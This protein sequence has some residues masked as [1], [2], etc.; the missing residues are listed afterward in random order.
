MYVYI[1]IH[2]VEM[3]EMVFDRF[4]SWSETFLTTLRPSFL[5]VLV[6]VTAVEETGQTLSNI[7]N[8]SISA[9]L[10][11]RLREPWQP[12]L[13]LIS[14]LSWPQKCVKSGTFHGWQ[15][16]CRAK[17]CETLEGGSEG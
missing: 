7:Q 14:V 11:V 3:L 2:I 5:P 1:Y 8:L 13:R 12:S 17:L 6:R 16:C 10:R 15:S 4:A 9:S